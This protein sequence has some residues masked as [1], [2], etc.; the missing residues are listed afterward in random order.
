MILV[1]KFFFCL[2]FSAFVYLPVFAQAGFLS[3]NDSLNNDTVISKV[4]LLNEIAVIGQ[5]FE[6][7]T[8]D[9]PPHHLITSSPHYLIT[10]SPHHLISP[11]LLFPFYHL[12]I[13][14]FIH[15]H[16]TSLPHHLITTPKF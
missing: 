13:H 8:F 10:S 15:H 2:S 3:A 11:F 12:L 6:T 16:I 9:F 4:F 7:N 1:K 14:S 5:R